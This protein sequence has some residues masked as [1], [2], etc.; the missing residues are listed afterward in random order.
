MDH[1]Q[2][3]IFSLREDEVD[4]RH[5]DHDENAE[6]EE[7]C[8]PFGKCLQNNY[9]YI[10]YCQQANVMCELGTMFPGQYGRVTHLIPSP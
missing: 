7:C 5:E 2:A 6:H 3:E 9:D 4:D 10:L 8:L 1:L